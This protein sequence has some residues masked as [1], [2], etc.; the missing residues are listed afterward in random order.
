MLIVS[1][2]VILQDP[3]FYCLFHL[4]SLSLS[5]SLSAQVNDTAKK[6]VIYQMIS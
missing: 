1:M 3:V 6:K 2:L 4:L 5:L